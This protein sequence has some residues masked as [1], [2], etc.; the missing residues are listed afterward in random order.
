MPQKK[1]KCSMEIVVA[2]GV[3]EVAV[4]DQT[5]YVLH[6]PD[7]GCCSPLSAAC[8]NAAP[9]WAPLWRER[10]Q[11]GQLPNLCFPFGG[12]SGRWEGVSQNNTAATLMP[13]GRVPRRAIRQCGTAYWPLQYALV[14]ETTPRLCVCVSV[15]LFNDPPQVTSGGRTARPCVSESPNRVA[16]PCGAVAWRGGAPGTSVGNN[17]RPF[18]A[19]VGPASAASSPGRTGVDRRLLPPSLAPPLPPAVLIEDTGAGRY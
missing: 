17:G 15:H 12:G 4:P 5:T 10:F 1:E 6:S 11:Y 9:H 14:H 13:W 2:C 18:G 7:D 16:P 3:C 19:P 8:Y